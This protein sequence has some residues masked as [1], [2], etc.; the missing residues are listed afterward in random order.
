[1][2]RFGAISPPTRGAKPI[3]VNAS[4]FS[5]NVAPFSLPARMAV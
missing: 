5:R 1:M 2:S 3:F 4:T